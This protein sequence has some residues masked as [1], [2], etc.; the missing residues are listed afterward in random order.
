MQQDWQARLRHR[1]VRHPP[2]VVT[3]LVCLVTTPACFVCFVILICDSTVC[4]S[5]SISRTIPMM[6]KNTIQH[7]P[8]NITLQQENLLHPL[9]HYCLFKMMLLAP[10]AMYE[11]QSGIIGIRIS[12]WHWW[13]LLAQMQRSDFKVALL[14]LLAQ[15]QCTNFKVVLLESRFQSGTGGICCHPAN[16]P[17]TLFLMQCTD[18]KMVL[19]YWHPPI[20]QC[21]NHP[22]SI[23]NVEIPITNF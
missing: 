4:K 15:V 21:R 19:C 5:F 23:T 1:P 2:Q 11:F 10:A 8:F 14:H 22:I 3:A 13:H 12:K 16:F 9:W 20:A 7:Q 18:F 6:M 17:Q